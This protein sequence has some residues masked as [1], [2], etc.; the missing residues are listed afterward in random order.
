MQNQYQ[1][2][3]SLNWLSSYIARAALGI[4]RGIIEGI[5]D[6]IVRRALLLGFA[7]A[8]KVITALSDGIER[9]EEQVAEIGRQFL[10]T[11][12]P[13]FAD[14][15]L[16]ALAEKIEDQETKELVLVL[17]DPFVDIIRILT[18]ADKDDKGQ[19]KARLKELAEDK[20]SRRALILFAIQLAEGVK[21][22]KTRA[23]II[24]LLMGAL[25]NGGEFGE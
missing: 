6:G 10:S 21:N 5:K 13:A 20:A 9:N 1:A 15:E 24:G 7:P 17:A 16:T 14:V 23:L 25:E 4:I 8:E 12:V 2:L 11:D 19:V 3:K 18:D 22:E